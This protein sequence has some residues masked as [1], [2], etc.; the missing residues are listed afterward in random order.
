MRQGWKDYERAAQDGPLALAIKVVCGVAALVAI[1]WVF[2][3]VFGTADT[4]ASVA[5]EAVSV[6]HEQYGP[7]AAVVKYEWFKD[8]AAQLAR[9]QADL[10]IYEEN[11]KRCAV[12]QVTRDERDAC[13]TTLSEYTGAKVSYNDLAAQYNSNMSKVNW[14]F[15]SASLPREVA[16]YTTNKPKTGGTK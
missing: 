9:K 2:G 7:R 5:S 1:V 4:A 8:A 12:R 13:N 10:T 15:A 6:A 3:L 16:P 11:A 14:Q